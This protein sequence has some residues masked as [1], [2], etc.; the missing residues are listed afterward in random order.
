[1]PGLKLKKPAI[2]LMAYYWYGHACNSRYFE[3]IA[4]LDIS[5]LNQDIFDKYQ[6]TITKENGTKIPAP[7]LRK[8]FQVEL[9]KVLLAASNR[10]FG[11]RN[12]DLKE[13]LGKNWKTAKIAYELRKLRERGAVEK[14]KSSHYYRL[15]KEGY[16]WIFYSFF[17]I[18]HTVK[19]LISTKYEKSNFKD[20]GNSSNLEVA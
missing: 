4:D 16:V 15:T 3:T 19:P 1:M 20:C 18:E 11:F 2:N 17:N 14:I 8:K 5:I 6:T 12:K 13:I 9:L 7:D 10:F